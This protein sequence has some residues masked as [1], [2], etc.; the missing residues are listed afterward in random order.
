[1]RDRARR[2]RGIVEWWFRPRAIEE[3][4]LYRRLGVPIFRTVLMATLGRLLPLVN[5]RLEGRGIGP[6]ET[7]E[8][9]TRVN[10]TYHLV[11]GIAMLGA[12]VYVIPHRRDPPYE[13]IVS[14][15]L[16]N[17]YLVLLQR[18]NR[19]RLRRAMAR[20]RSGRDA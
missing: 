1:M 16:L 17:L 14:G 3:G 5:Y 4:P 15:C 9:W 18:Y 7:F 10:E 20:S 11:L 6:L 2:T 12:V 19:V 8:R 13:L